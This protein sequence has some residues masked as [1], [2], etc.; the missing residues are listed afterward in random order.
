MVTLNNVL[1]VNEHLL[2]S[3]RTKFSHFKQ[4]RVAN[5]SPEG[6]NLG[7]LVHKHLL[8]LNLHSPPSDI[9]CASHVMSFNYVSC[10]FTGNMRNGFMVA[11]WTDTK[12]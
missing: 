7:M 11:S 3:L 4:K 10:L 9:L 1:Y 12:K 2:Q 6:Q 5:I 8:P